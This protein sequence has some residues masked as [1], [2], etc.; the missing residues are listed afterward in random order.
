MCSSTYETKRFG[1]IGK[2]Q[3]LCLYGSRELCRIGTLAFLPADPFQLEFA[4]V[5]HQLLV[6]VEHNVIGITFGSHFDDAHIQQISEI[7]Q[8][9][10]IWGLKLKT[11][12]AVPSPAA[13]PKPRN[14]QSPIPNPNPHP[15]QQHPTQKPSALK[16]S[17]QIN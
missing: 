1:E 12:T 10:Q 2:C 15:S 14:L 13:N 5:M 6:R 17:M 7:V 9:S 16:C 8:P 11:N 3:G 4:L